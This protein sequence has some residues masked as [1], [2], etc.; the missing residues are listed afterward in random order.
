MRTLKFFF[1]SSLF[2]GAVAC[3]SRKKQKSVINKVDTTI[4]RKDESAEADSFVANSIDTSSYLELP[5][6]DTS[7]RHGDS[8]GYI[9]TFSIRNSNFRIVHQN[10]MFNGV[11]EKNKDGKWLRVMQF[12]KLD[13]HNDYDISQDL[14][15]DGY[16]DLI[17][18]WKW[19]GDIHFFDTTKNEFSDTANC[20]IA[21]DWALLDSSKH[22]FYENKFGKLMYS[23]VPSN[24]FT[25]KNSSRIDIATLQ[26]TY[27]PND[28]DYIFLRG[29]LYVEGSKHQIEKVVPN[30]KTSVIDFDYQKFWAERYKK[31]L[32]GR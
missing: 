12:D 2:F 9:D 26:I 1:F 22:I 25:F 3:N 29:A 14:N 15:G 21:I 27:D 4:F 5:Y 32:N 7:V 30:K 23:P 16:N 28:Y 11:V 31:L 17:F 8:R 20:S 13:S 10:K 24:L 18:Y 19:S 6:Y